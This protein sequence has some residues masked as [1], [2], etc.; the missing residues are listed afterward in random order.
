M[1]SSDNEKVNGI[2]EKIK[3]DGSNVNETASGALEFKFDAGIPKTRLIFEEGEEDSRASD[4][5]LDFDAQSDAFSVSEAEQFAPVSEKADS[6]DTAADEQPVKIREIG[7][8]EFII[9]DTFVVSEEFGTSTVDDYVSTIWKTYVPRFTEATENKYYFANNSVL[10]EQNAKSVEKTFKDGKAEEAAEVRTPSAVKVQQRAAEDSA[11]IEDPIAEIDVKTKAVVV[12]VNGKSKDKKDTI[13]VFKFPEQKTQKEE[14]TLTEE[15]IERLGITNLTGHK[16]DDT[17]TPVSEKQNDRAENEA[18]SDASYTTEAWSD[19]TPDA[20]RFEEVYGKDT[21]IAETET[22]IPKGVVRSEKGYAND[23]AEYNSFATRDT[24][25]DKFLD[26]IMASKVRLVVAV[27]LGLLTLA[28]ENIYLFGV[29]IF[30]NVL[31][32]PAAI[33]ACLI[34]SMLLITLPENFKGIKAVATGKI[35]P[36]LTSLFFGISIFAYSLT[37]ALLPISASVYPLFGFVYSVMAVNGVIATYCL[38]AADFAAF[39]LISEKG[40][41]KILDTKLTR[42][43]ERENIA[44]DGAVDEYKSKT[45]RVFSTGFVSDFF[46]TSSKHSENSANN[47]LLIAVSVG[48]ALVSGVVMFFIG[49][50]GIVSGFSAFALVIAL[51][52]PAFSLLSH[53]LPFAHAQDEALGNAGAII[54][55]RSVSE[56]SG[57]DVVA[58]EDTEVFGQ[59]DVSFKSISL[60]DKRADFR[61]TMRKMSSLFAAIGG[62]LSFVF[63]AS[64]N[65]KYP[66]AEKVVIEDDGAE[67]IVDGKRIMAG[68]VEYMQ[69]HGIK[70]PLRNESSVG[71]TRI[72][73]AAEDGELFAKFTV[74]YSFS[75]EFALMLSAMR[76][77][78]IVPLVYTRDFN[79]NNEF[80]RFLTGGADAIRVMRK[81]TPAK[82]PVVY[83][84]IS[85]GMVT[86]GEKTSAINLI[87][88][89]GKYSHFQS[90]ISVSELLACGVGAILAVVIALCNMATAIPS[91][92]LGVWQIAWSVV[93]AILSKGTFKRGKE[94]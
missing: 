76:E 59:D 46:K 85:A 56:F 94:K 18:D 65:K 77:K 72:M 36:E 81:Y 6:A 34:A 58:F 44:L 10:K 8:D 78:G 20:D 74:N 40:T 66:A 15:E 69:R 38:D 42:N 73:Y 21:E 67:G 49:T 52:M 45:A 30:S 83:A 57:V 89:A 2:F 11:N 47:A 19:T 92:L 60:S 4:E 79:I 16:W 3:N 54:G 24:F 12:N 53:K 23:T 26:K 50:G 22:D 33:D 13:N 84:K 39:R 87:L 43:L 62:P 71:S 9:P 37:M 31:V 1:V 61:E 68:N 86:L 91:V 70:I 64:L 88:L 5:S 63:A 27:L 17:H 82:E 55:E 51:A 75:E 90:Y 14:K 25:K 29:D 28:F 7:E 48:V 32:S 93:L 35:A 80:M 41:K